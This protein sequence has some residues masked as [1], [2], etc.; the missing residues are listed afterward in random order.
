MNTA[1][2]STVR[3][4]L[5]ALEIWSLTETAPRG[6]STINF[7]TKGLNKHS[8]L[9]ENTWMLFYIYNSMLKNK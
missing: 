2:Y 9:S 7:N 1:G 6:K 8:S 3:T 4:F 5:E